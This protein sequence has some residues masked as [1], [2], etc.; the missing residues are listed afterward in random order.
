MGL[1]VN[2]CPTKINFQS[3]AAALCLYP[4]MTA[5]FHTPLLPSVRVK[6]KIK[7][8][9]KCAYQLVSSN[10]LNVCVVVLI[11]RLIC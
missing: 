4:W 6:K 10:I 1:F 7:P 9:N 8:T 3:K 2:V 5:S 11:N